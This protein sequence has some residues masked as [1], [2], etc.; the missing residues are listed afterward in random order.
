MLKW[1]ALKFYRG[2]ITSMT[3]QENAEGEKALETGEAAVLTHG[4]SDRNTR[5]GWR[6]ETF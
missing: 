5:M 6:T 2:A 3:A 1:E 4:H